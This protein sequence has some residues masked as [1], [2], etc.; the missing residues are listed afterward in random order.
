MDI[1]AL[2][3]TIIVLIVG[4]VIISIPLWLA[5]KALTAGKATLGAAMLGTLLGIFVFTF[6][7]FL[8]YV[9]SSTFVDQA[10]AGAVS[11]LIGF[12]AFLA[13]YKGLFKVGWI[14]ALAIAILAIIFTA[15]IA[16]AIGA[17]IAAFG[18]SLI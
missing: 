9:V 8:T 4:W 10:T 13:L 14:G 16:V 11:L 7:Y 3:I 18:F 6:I 12:L 1:E 17:I 2:L 5:A 15:I